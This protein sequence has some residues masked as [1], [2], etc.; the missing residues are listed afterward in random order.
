M[1]IESIIT[2]IIKKVFALLIFIRC[3]F[4]KLDF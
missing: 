4:Q 3:K 2:V 1:P